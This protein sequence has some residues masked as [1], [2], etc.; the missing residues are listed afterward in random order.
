MKE[1]KARKRVEHNAKK[2]CNEQV[3]ILILSLFTVASARNQLGEKKGCKS[4][5]TGITL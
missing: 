5:Q 3:Y 4:S 1:A 2:Q